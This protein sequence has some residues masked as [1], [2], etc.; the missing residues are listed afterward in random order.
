[1]R[2]IK[3][4]LQRWGLGLRMASVGWGMPQLRPDSED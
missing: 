1:M 4:L 3:A 2:N